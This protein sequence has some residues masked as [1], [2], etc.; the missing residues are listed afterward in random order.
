[1]IFKGKERLE[2]WLV[3][4]LGNPGIQYEN[5]RHNAGFAA[6]DRFAER[7]GAQFNKNKHSAL[8]GECNVGGK[9]V[10]IAKPQTYMNLSGKAVSE[11]CSFYKIPSDR[12]IVM[13]DDISLDVGRLRVRCKG[14]HGGH[15][16]MKDIIELMGTEDIPRVKI[17]VGAKPNPEYDLKD[18]V[19]G[20][21]PTEQRA[22]FADAAERAAKAAEEIINRGPD[23][24]MNKYNG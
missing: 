18:W 14:S 20:K 7:N 19:L 21:F 9:R 24:A 13:F 11:L 10:I 4:G 1:M 12:V 2:R 17:G 16:G 6:A 5:T 23:S 22:D 3:V 15:N 8:F